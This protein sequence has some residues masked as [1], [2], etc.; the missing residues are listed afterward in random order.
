[1]AWPPTILLL[2][3]FLPHPSWLFSSLFCCGCVGIWWNHFGKEYHWRL[4][5][6]DF[7]SCTSSTWCL[8]IMVCLHYK[9]IPILKIAW[10]KISGMKIAWMENFM[11]EDS[12]M[13]N[14]MN[15]SSMNTFFMTW[16]FHEQKISWKKIVGK[17]IARKHKFRERKFHEWK[18]QRWIF[19][20]LK[21]QT[22][23]VISEDCSLPS[24]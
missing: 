14:F 10:L 5:C 23:A 18:F 24:R 15:E 13:E 17:K 3:P 7:A 8:L 12:M 20:N 1:M 16:K 4:C 6:K 11:K 2:K 9:K 21:L 19:L 22:F